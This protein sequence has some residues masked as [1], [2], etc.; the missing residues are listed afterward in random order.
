[1]R[2]IIILILVFSVSSS[3][4]TFDHHEN[5]GHSKAEHAKLWKYFSKNTFLNPPTVR[6]AMDVNKPSEN[7]RGAFNMGGIDPLFRTL[8]KVKTAR[9][10]KV[11]YKKRL[12]L[13]REMA[14]ADWM[15]N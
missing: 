2:L 6:D 3:E 10:P 1:M 13:K 11:T 9:L 12:S 7:N 5:D 8:Y 14:N 4:N 15:F